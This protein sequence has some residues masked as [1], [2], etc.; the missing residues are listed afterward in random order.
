MKDPF[1]SLEGAA[2]QSHDTDIQRDIN[3]KAAMDNIRKYC[4]N[5]SNRDLAMIGLALI[6]DRYSKVERFCDEIRA[7]FCLDEGVDDDHRKAICARAY[8]N[9]T[10]RLSCR[11]VK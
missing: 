6:E 5:G 1:M 3:I 2:F 7:T 9:L 8:N 11:P 4:V 10:R